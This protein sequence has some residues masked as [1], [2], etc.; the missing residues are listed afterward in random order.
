MN[1]YQRIETA[2]ATALHSLNIE[3]RLIESNSFF[4]SLFSIYDFFPT[5]DIT[6]IVYGFTYHK[7]S[8]L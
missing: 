3:Y 8:S 7:F 4:D 1:V 5:K 6:Y 2:D